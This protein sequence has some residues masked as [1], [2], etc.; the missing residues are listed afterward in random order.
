MKT[1]KQEKRPEPKGQEASSISPEERA[2]RKRIREVNARL[3]DIQRELE[4]LKTELEELRLSLKRPAKENPDHGILVKRLN[5]IA[6][7]PKKLRE[8]AILLRDEKRRLRELSPQSAAA[9]L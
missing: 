5:Q 8:E 3:E 2:T 4:P 1:E 9:P 6:N 7:E